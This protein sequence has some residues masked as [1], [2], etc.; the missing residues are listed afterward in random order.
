MKDR[1]NLKDTFIKNLKAPENRT[2][3]YDEIVTGMTLRVTPT[4]HKSFALRYWYAGQSKQITIGKYGDVSLGDAREKARNLKQLVS[5]GID[6]AAEK[7]ERKKVVHVETFKELADQ[8]K[9]IHLSRLREKTR[10]EHNRI[11]N[12]ELEPAFGKLPAKELSRSQILSLLDKK[13]VTD[14]K[15]TMANR[16]RARLHSIYEFGIHRGSLK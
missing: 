10:Q 13:A 16:I 14:G 15:P 8:F 11:I 1:I 9:E 3:Y 4:G 6:P 7:A 12:N 5:G 2:E